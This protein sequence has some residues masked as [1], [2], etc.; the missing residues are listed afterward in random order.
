MVCSRRCGAGGQG[1]VVLV[2][3]YMTMGF[4]MD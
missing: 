3:F 1:I 2:Y 4:G